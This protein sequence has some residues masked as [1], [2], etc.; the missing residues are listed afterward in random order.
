MLINRK[1]IWGLILLVII[2]NG[3]GV[4]EP[5]LRNDDPVLYA[6]IAK[7]MAVSGDWIG[8]FSAGQPWL[9]KPHF[10]FWISAFSFKIFGI[11]A[12]AYFL[13]GYL[14]HLLGAYYTYRLAKLLY[15][16]EVGLIALLIY[17]SSVHLM[18]SGSFD[19]RAEAYLLGQI[20]GI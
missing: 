11:N 17:L 13:P 20:I 9:D 16:A 15:N 19:V 18:L 4:F 8:L 1:L 12:F 10:P 7:H 14:F 3:I 2:V 6:N 5:L